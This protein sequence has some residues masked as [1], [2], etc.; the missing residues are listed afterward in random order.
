MREVAAAAAES[1]PEL[2]SSRG[3]VAG[4]HL[5]PGQVASATGAMVVGQEELDRRVVETGCFG[6]GCLRRSWR[7]MSLSSGVNSPAFRP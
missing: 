1:C 6:R 5:R 2:R 7:K 3:T 4:C